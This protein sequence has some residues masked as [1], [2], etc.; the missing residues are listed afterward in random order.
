MLKSLRASSPKSLISAIRT[1]TALCS[2]DETKR[3]R[4][5]RM[6]RIRSEQKQLFGRVI[7][8][9]TYKKEEDFGSD[10][11]NINHVKSESVESISPFDMNTDSAE[12]VPDVK[13][14]FPD[15]NNEFYWLSQ[16]SHVKVLNLNSKSKIKA[17]DKPSTKK[18]PPGNGAA[19]PKSASSEIINDAEQN[20]SHTMQMNTATSVSPAS[21]IITAKNLLQ[22]FLQSNRSDKQ[23][24]QPQTIPFDDDALKSIVN[25]PLI[26]DKNAPHQVND[27]LADVSIRLPSISKVL[28]ATM[29]ESARIALKKWKLGQIAALGLDGFKRYERETLDRGKDFHLAIENF[30]SRGQIPAPDSSIIKLWQSIDQSLSELEPKPVLL[31]QPILHADLKYQGIID[32]VSIVK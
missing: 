29:P 16:T 17:K 21:A 14:A 3:E 19:S 24:Q 23:P 7:R 22:Q 13:L 32:N 9:E 10:G 12:N 26:C 25:Y 30:L 31:E 5:A 27:V 6:L 1:Q 4:R 15:Q 20:D 11:I 28:Q 18:T 2:H 8:D